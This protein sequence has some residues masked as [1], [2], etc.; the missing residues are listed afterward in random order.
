MNTHHQ[1][2]VAA[3]APLLQDG[4]THLIV[5][6]GA[7]VL[8][9]GF[10]RF[11][12]RY[13]RL[14]VFYFT[15]AQGPLGQALYAA[16]GLPANDFTTNLVIVDGKPHCKMASFSAAMRAL[17]WPWRVLA[18]VDWLPHRVAD[19]FYDRIAGNRYTLFGRRAQCALPCAGLKDRLL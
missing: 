9:N 4:V 15:T 6:D 16:L 5:F 11:V 17:G 14:G 8:C 1:A 19:W 3:I 13:D 12:A 7:C 18:M 10:A 2:D